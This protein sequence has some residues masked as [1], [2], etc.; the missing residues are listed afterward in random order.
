MGIDVVYFGA[1]DLSQVLGVPGETKHPK[2]V[3][4]I[5]SGAEKAI[6]YGKYAG[7]FVPLTVDDM[8]WNLDIGMNFVTYSVDSAMVFSNMQTVVNSFLKETGSR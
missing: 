4:A 1:Y 2:V 3:K 7:G 8:K 6:K 5:Q